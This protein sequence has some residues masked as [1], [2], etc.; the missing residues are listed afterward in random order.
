MILGIDAS[1]LRGGGGVTH[2]VEL[3]RA[4]DAPA[5][6]FTRVIVWGA[7][8]ILGK[9]EERPW[10]VKSHVPV[11]E[12]SLVHRAVWQRFGLAKVAAQARCDILFAPGGSYTGHFQPGVTMSRNLLPFEWRELL[13]FGWSWLT[14]KFMLLHF[15]HAR[16][17]R[18]AAGLIF[19]N[20][21][22]RDV[23]MR[24][25]KT[26]AGRSTIVPHG[27]NLRFM[28]PPREQLPLDRYSAEQPIRLLYVS[29]IDVYKHQWHVAEAVAQLRAEGLPV[30]LDLIGPAYAP[31]LR[32]LQRTL[33][34]V[35]PG[36]KF[37]TYHGTVPHEDLHAHYARADVCVFASSCENMPNILLEGM[38]FGLPIACSRLGP[39][40]EV[41][42]EAGVYFD[43]LSPGDIARTLS[44]LLA[45]PALRTAKA[46]AAFTAAGAYSWKR[47]AHETF[48][49]LAVLARGDGGTA[50]AALC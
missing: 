10:L 1:N 22:A 41:L 23:V 2:L 33:Y 12:K 4:A 25:I 28:R 37:V 3:L 35:D 5:H 24:S 14:V 48:G 43:P 49:F 29:I 8:A 13:R 21:H 31:A 36:G 46:Q 50:P 7:H 17:Y 42:G 38:A 19:L 20:S 9:L 15:T 47:C 26:T 39:M 11:L 27:I 18:R 30:T 6:G 44:Q 34:R 45:S 40:P 32:R 16:S